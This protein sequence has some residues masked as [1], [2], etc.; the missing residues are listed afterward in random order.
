MSASSMLIQAQEAQPKKKNPW[1]GLAGFTFFLSFIWGIVDGGHGG[2]LEALSSIACCLSMIFLV[3]GGSVAS[4]SAAAAKE[5]AQHGIQNPLQVIAPGSVPAQAPVTSKT[6]DNSVSLTIEKEHWS[7]GEEIALRFKAPP[8]P[9]STK[10][11]V[12]IVPADVESGSEARN[13]EATVSFLYLQGHTSGKLTFPSPGI[14]N[15][16]IR[17]HDAD[18]P[19]VAEQVAEVDFIVGDSPIGIP[20][21]I[22]EQIADFDEEKIEQMVED[23]SGTLQKVVDESD[24]DIEQLQQLTTQSLSSEL[25]ALPDPV[26][27]K[28]ESGIYK[29]LE[30]LKFD[31][32]AKKAKAAAGITAGLATAGVVAG[33]T[34]QAMEQTG[35][36]TEEVEEA[37]AQEKDEIAQ[38]ADETKAAVEE[39]MKQ[40][41]EAKAAA[42]EAAKQ[43]AEEAARI[44]K[45]AEEAARK[46][47]ED[48]GKAVEEL[49]A[50]SKAE[51]DVEETP[52]GE[53]VVEEVEVVETV[54]E[55]ISSGIDL[56][57]LVVQ[58]SEARFASERS[59]IIDSVKGSTYSFAIKVDRVE[60]SLGIGLSE[61]LRNGRS[62]SGNIEG[63]DID[64]SVRMPSSRN[65]EMD[66]INEGTVVDVVASVSD[67]NS[68]RKRLDL[69]HIG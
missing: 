59:S 49:E 60:R 35:K 66:S 57:D 54:V 52:I 33:V 51:A 56:H 42:E 6:M 58:L 29:K 18:D 67:W 53:E 47:V 20:G 30:A 8:W 17:L 24:L 46:A 15:W 25:S 13:D 5:A 36:V 41:E 48:A 1:F 64:V 37:V 40:A 26:K 22:S 65:D 23:Y 62:L 14:G 11:W 39:A 45:E 63:D 19:E 34:A 68:L 38:A 21:N 27:T 10:A 55:E 9:V 2:P 32:D 16:S 44:T 7:D 28:V 12:G 4:A 43:A 31:V 3:V 50:D 61:Y 69:D